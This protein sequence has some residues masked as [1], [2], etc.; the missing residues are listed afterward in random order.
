MSTQVAA[1]GSDDTRSQAE[2]G[3]PTQKEVLDRLVGPKKDKV[4]TPSEAKGGILTH[5][6][7][8]DK[9]LGLKKGKVLIEP[10]S[11]V[12]IRGEP[13]AGKTTLGLQILSAN[14]EEIRKVEQAPKVV[15]FS[16][17]RDA[18]GV[19]K[20]VKEKYDFFASESLASIEGDKGNIV[21]LNADMMDRMISQFVKRPVRQIIKTVLKDLLG[22]IGKFIGGMWTGKPAVTGEGAGGSASSLVEA[23]FDHMETR[24]NAPR[25]EASL[26]PDKSKY[27]IVFVDSLN[28]LMHLLQ[29]HDRCKGIPERLLLNAICSG[30]RSYFV[31]SIVIFTGEV[32]PISVGGAGATPG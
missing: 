2:G 29:K 28:V 9:L 10:G 15:F 13:G 19:L 11:I 20:A 6:E 8:L 24:Q 32:V 17:E 7:V 27:R 16:L 3:I 30:F 26:G 31:N 22:H 4:F 21:K 12:L 23:I 18:K 1:E 5:I 25:V 14:L